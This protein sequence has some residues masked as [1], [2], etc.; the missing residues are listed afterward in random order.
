MLRFSGTR[1]RT[2]PESRDT[3]TSG[4]PHRS[5]LRRVT[6]DQLLVGIDK[7]RIYLFYKSETWQLNTAPALRKSKDLVTSRSA[8]AGD[9]SND[10]LEK[11]T[12]Y[13]PC[14]LGSNLKL[15]VERPKFPVGFRQ[16]L[17]PVPFSL[18]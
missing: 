2:F 13:P 10:H 5:Q 1:P 14:P 8:P 3:M 17:M 16:I 15:S 12:E 11:L 9:Q 7:N 4:P 18:R 6:C